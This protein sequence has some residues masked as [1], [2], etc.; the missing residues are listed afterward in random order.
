M[1]PIVSLTAHKD[2]QRPRK[3][4]TYTYILNCDTEKT[5]HILSISL[6]TK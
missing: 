4:G 6:I 3:A 2:A 1:H 5:P